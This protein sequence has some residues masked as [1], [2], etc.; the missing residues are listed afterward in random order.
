MSALGFALYFYKQLRRE[1]IE[2]VEAKKEESIRVRA[3]G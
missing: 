2:D 3:A 1:Q